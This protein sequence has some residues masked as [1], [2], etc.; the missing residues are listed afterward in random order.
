A[1]VLMQIVCAGIAKVGGGGDTYYNAAPRDWLARRTGYQAR[2]N[3]A[4]ANSWRRWAA[5]LQDWRLPT[6]ATLMP[7]C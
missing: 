6:W 7:V 2:A 4:Q 5:T 1:T 3:S